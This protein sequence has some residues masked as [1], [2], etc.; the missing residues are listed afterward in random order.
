MTRS[1]NWLGATF[2]IC[3]ALTMVLSSGC[4]SE[5]LFDRGEL[6]PLTPVS[7][8]GPPSFSRDVVPALATCI[9]C[10]GGGAGGWVYDGGPDAWTQTLTRVDQDDPASSLLL[11]KGSGAV[12][13]AGGVYFA[14][15]S[16][17]YDAIL[18]W[19]V[20]GAKDN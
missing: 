12:S 17:A 16:V 14:A 4:G 19:I 1:M 18:A 13:H 11:E 7:D 15:G 2:S 6:S 5:H 9:S 3:C 20:D 8:G 10:H